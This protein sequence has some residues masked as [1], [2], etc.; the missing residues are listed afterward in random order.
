[1][2]D[3]VRSEMGKTARLF[4]SGLS[5][6]SF[7]S[8][9]KE[10]VLTIKRTAVSG[11]TLV[12]LGGFAMIVLLLFFVRDV[13]RHLSDPEVMGFDDRLTNVLPGEATWL[14]EQRG[15]RWGPHGWYLGPQETGYLRVKIPGVRPGTVNARIWAFS[16]GS[17]EVRIVDTNGV[18]VITEDMLDGRILHYSFHPNS[19]LTI[20][21]SNN[22]SEEQ[23]V[24]DRLAFAWT[25]IGDH[26]PSILPFLTCLVCAVVGWGIVVSVQ[27]SGESR[28]IWFGGGLI[29]IAAS[30]G[31]YERWTFLDMARLLPLDPDAVGF[32]EY[33]RS[34]QW[35]T[36]NHGFYSGTFAQREPFHVGALSL[37][38]HVWGDSLASVRLYTVS[39]STI[40]VIFTG[41]FIWKL[42]G[43][44]WWAA[45]ASWIMALSPA[46][47]DESIR[48]LRVESY[49]VL[50]LVVLSLWL[51]SR[52]W[53]GASLL[54]LAVGL[55]TLSRAP[56]VTAVLPVFWICW[57]VNVLRVKKG[58]EPIHPRQWH[59][60]QLAAVSLIA[61]ALFLPHLY[62]LYKV[63]GDP[64]WPSY[65]YARWLAN[66]EFPERLGTPGFPSKEEFEQSPYAGPPIT[67]GEYLFGLHSP[68]QLLW[69]QIKGWV[70]S[71]VYMSV[72]PTP[73]LK[74][75][76]FLQQASGSRSMLRQVS[77]WTIGIFLGLLIL[78]AI[79]W[80]GLW[81]HPQYWFASAF[82][83]WGTWYAAQ[84]YSARLVEPFRHTAHVYPLLLFCFLWGGHWILHHMSRMKPPRLSLRAM[85]IATKCAL[86]SKLSSP[87]R[88]SSGSSC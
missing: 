32:Q 19:E 23:L 22:H 50:F 55:M 35:F 14:I 21:A 60:L 51:W 74:G 82:S 10:G 79:G 72:S 78:T 16:A 42:C 73:R 62:G 24:L 53:V 15:G 86:D 2:D 83:I 77:F 36:D 34:L 48:G 68:K 85:R 27:S 20:H 56:A 47:I 29:L 80:V 9:G 38:F 65:G 8:V 25:E 75:L 59:F 18:R 5:I 49:G 71:V 46:W 70:E 4:K 41:V 40:L 61:F 12:A 66:V 64:S 88:T 11:W 87:A 43:K 31:L 52:G 69:S 44:W 81:V 13:K 84:L 37:W 26:L 3:D 57:G 30:V 7:C 28:R 58:L 67:Y 17:L 45:M 6:Q 33:A 1:M 76:L 63:H 54:G 39:I